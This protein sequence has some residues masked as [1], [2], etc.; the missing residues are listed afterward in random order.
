[1]A[2]LR[3]YQLDLCAYRS[4]LGH[5]AELGIK[6]LL[7]LKLSSAQDAMSLVNNLNAYG[8]SVTTTGLVSCDQ[9]NDVID[10]DG[11][12]ENDNDNCAH[13]KSFPAAFHRGNTQLVHQ[14]L[15]STS[16]SWIKFQLPHLQLCSSA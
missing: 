1:M 4:G 10:V 5:E 16:R 13:L 2:L 7:E 15:N 11:H 8:Y 3:E 14:D 6:S 9:R 12:D